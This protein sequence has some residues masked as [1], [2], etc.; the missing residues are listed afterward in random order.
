MD[1]ILNSF[2]NAYWLRPENALWK[3]LSVRAM[4]EFQFEAPALDLGCGDGIFSFLRA[5]GRMDETEDVFSV[6][7]LEKF[8]SNVDVYDC[9]T[10]PSARRIVRAPQYMIEVGLD[11]KK[12]LLSKADKL[13]LYHNLVLADANK[14][15]PFEDESFATV[16]S[17]IIYWLD[18]P[19]EVFR[20]IHRVLRKGGTCCVMLVSPTLLESSYYQRFYLRGGQDKFQFL[21]IIDR[22]RTSEN[23]KVVKSYEEWKEMIEGA[24]FKI[25]KCIPHISKTITQIWDVGLRPIFPMLKKM[26]DALDGDTFLEIKREWVDFFLRIGEPIMELDHVLGESGGNSY[27]CFLLAKQT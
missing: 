21:E 4:E 7:H 12:S 9:D 23:V 19:S 14:K 3:A 17:D 13:G 2:L 22:G 6:N 16:F 26:T 11:H 8:Y 18:N 15:L 25:K 24:G 10:E 1:E 20:E 27:L 5:G